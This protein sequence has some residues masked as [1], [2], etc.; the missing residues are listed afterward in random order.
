VLHEYFDYSTWRAIAPCPELDEFVSAVMTS[1]RETGGEP[2]VARQLPLW[3]EELGFEIRQ[4]RPIVNIVKP[5]TMLWLWLRTFIEVG[6]RRL[7]DIGYL[8]PERSERI[9]EAFKAFEAA[10]GSRM[11]TPGVLEIVARR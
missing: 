6:R 1:W 3:L 10:P 7:I 5:D 2:D 11:I 4:M 9:W 8:T